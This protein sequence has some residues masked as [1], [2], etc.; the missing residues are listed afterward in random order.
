[1]S[2]FKSNRDGERCPLSKSR[3][4]VN[5]A[6]CGHEGKDMVDPTYVAWWFRRYGFHAMDR[7]FFLKENT[8]RVAEQDGAHPGFSQSL[9]VFALDALT[10]GEE[11]T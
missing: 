6:L 11:S 2:A 5:A 9:R 4:Q 8:R 3:L 7:P 1:L 10:S